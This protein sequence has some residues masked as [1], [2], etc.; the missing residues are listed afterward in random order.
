MPDL[1]DGDVAYF[2]INRVDDAIVALSHTVSVV[3]ARQ[4][5]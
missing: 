4:L 3:V 2:V 1:E 5:L